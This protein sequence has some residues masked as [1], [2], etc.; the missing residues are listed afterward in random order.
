MLRAA[1]FLFPPVGL[2]CLW[3]SPRKL[4]RKILGT[5]GLAF[6]SLVYAAL[7]IFL[8]IQFAGLQIEWRGGYV[9][10]LTWQKTSPNY[11]AL[12]RDRNTH[13]GP[14]TALA[15]STNAFWTGFRGPQ[16]DGVY[17][18]KPILT[19][20]PATG[21]R[22]LW[23]QPIG[24]GFSS[25]AVARGL[26]CTIE[27]RREDEV[28]AAYELESGREVW[29]QRWPGHFK[30]Y[31]NEDGP[32]TTPAYNDGKIYALGA[33]VNCAASKPPRASRSGRTI[34]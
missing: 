13:A 12:E 29:T 1:A 30:G 31:F 7:I 28:V 18:E 11:D 32:R 4:W 10:A 24:G 6:L 2:V 27:Q 26:A 34:S 8:L 22:L 20:W 14:A 3:R 17:D 19:N 15:A 9:P 5:L 21:L 33:L 16:R 25:F 23:R